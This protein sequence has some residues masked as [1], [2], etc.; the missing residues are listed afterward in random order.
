MTK[1]RLENETAREQWLRYLKIITD[2]DME[3][4][5]NGKFNEWINFFAKLIQKDTY[6]TFFELHP[7][8]DFALPDNGIIQVPGSYKRFFIM[9]LSLRVAIVLVDTTFTRILTN[10]S[11]D[12]LF[13][14]KELDL[15]LRTL[16][17]LGY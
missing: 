14:S 5:M 15:S 7:N 2:N 11:L 12:D 4:L 9:P 6:I 17:E 13:Q 10:P 1:E 3:K 8:M 16:T